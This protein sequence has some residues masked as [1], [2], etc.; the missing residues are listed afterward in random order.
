MPGAAPVVVLT[1]RGWQR[2]LG[3][4]PSILGR[5]VRLHNHALT[6]VGIAPDDAVGPVA[7]M[8]YVP[9]RCSQFC[10]GRSTTFASRRAV[11]RG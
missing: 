6:V 4:D 10:R 1:E 5:I 3:S 11:I 2:H 9:T 8:V 7:A